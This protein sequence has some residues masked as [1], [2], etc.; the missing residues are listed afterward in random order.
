MPWPSSAEIDSASTVLN[1]SAIGRRN[2]RVPL[3]CLNCHS[4]GRV[5]LAAQVP[6][7]TMFAQLFGRARHAGVRR[8]SAGEA[9]VTCREAETRLAMSSEERR[10]PT[11]TATSTPS[12]CMST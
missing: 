8:D 10:L 4:A 3:P 9:Q 2:E 12:A 1:D 6:D 11:R 5:A 7:E